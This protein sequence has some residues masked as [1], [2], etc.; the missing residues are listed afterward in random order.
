MWQQQAVSSGIEGVEGGWE[1]EIESE[2][3]TA[4]SELSMNPGLKCTQTVFAEWTDEN[5]TWG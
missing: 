3:I 4:F 2:L 1:S 5:M